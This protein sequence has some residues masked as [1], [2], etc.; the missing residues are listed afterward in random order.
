MTYSQ[1]ANIS[2]MKY[3]NDLYTKS[4]NVAEVD[5]K[6]TLNDIFIDGV[7]SPICHSLHKY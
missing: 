2:A 1:L 5:D 3:A 7:N 6:A 4:C